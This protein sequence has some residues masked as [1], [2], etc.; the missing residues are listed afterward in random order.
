MGTTEGVPE[1]VPSWGSVRIIR[2]I[3]VTA[4]ATH[5]IC[6]LLP[7]NASK[8]VTAP[9]PIVRQSGDQIVD[10]VPKGWRVYKKALGDLNGD[11]QKDAVIVCVSSGSNPDDMTAS[12]RAVLVVLFADQH[13]YQ[14]KCVLPIADVNGRDSNL[15]LEDLKIDHGN[16]VITVGNGATAISNIDFK[17]RWQRGNFELIGITEMHGNVREG[18]ESTQDYNL[19]T[20][21]VEST[22]STNAFG[23]GSQHPVSSNSSY[24]VLRAGAVAVV[25]NMNQKI[26]PP[27]VPGQ[28]IKLNRSVNVALGK[29]DWKGPSDL[30]A[31]VSAVHDDKV[32]FVSALVTEKSP[33]NL[34][35]LRL[36][37]EEKHYIASNAIITPSKEGLLIEARFLLSQMDSAM[38]KYMEETRESKIYRLSLEVVR[39]KSD[40]APLVVLS[41]NC[42]AKGTGEIHLTGTGAL[43][44][45]KDWDWQKRDD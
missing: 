36:K 33:N 45:L 29:A 21:Y 27:Q 18:N 24:Y 35:I 10:F 9:A 22:D 43:P 41:T 28:S 3:V 6:W 1:Q 12:V 44:L 39:P 32:L 30:S 4:I 11:G 16:I 34:T 7:A 23:D 17:W 25:P 37:D 40:A 15:Q 26:L 13:G 5:A 42:S 14:N 31:V 38:D 20:G 2:K 19:N 8:N